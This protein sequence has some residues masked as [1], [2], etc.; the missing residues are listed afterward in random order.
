MATIRLV[1]LVVVLLLLT[2]CK[3][4]CDNYCQAHKEPRP[5]PVVVFV[6]TECPKPDVPVREALPS[7]RMKI[8]TPKESVMACVAD[9]NY[10]MFRN[11]QLEDLLD[12]YVHP[13]AKVADP[14]PL[15]TIKPK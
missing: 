4:V 14:S 7:S 11:K 12:V 9:V 13:K 10:L 6:P 15:E 8:D 2:G 5:D 3:T 1:L